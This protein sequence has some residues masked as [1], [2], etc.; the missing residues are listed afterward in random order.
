[1]KAMTTAPKSSTEKKPEKR[2]D[3]KPRRLPSYERI[4]EINRE[5]ST[6]VK[7]LNF[8]DENPYTRIQAEMV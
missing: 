1:M 8:S 6:R 7:V 4:T 2:S 3:K 5:L